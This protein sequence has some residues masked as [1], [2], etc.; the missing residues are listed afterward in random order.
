MVDVFPPAKQR[1]ALLVFRDALGCR[2]TRS[3]EMSPEIGASTANRATST[4][5]LRAFSLW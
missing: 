2:T 5:S 1:E 3:A 4:R